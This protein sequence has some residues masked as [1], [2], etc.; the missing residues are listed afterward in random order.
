MLA[1]NMIAL[2]IGTPELEW[3]EE[4]K[5]V[6][7]AFIISKPLRWL[8]RL[9]DLLLGPSCMRSQFLHSGA[10]SM[11]KCF[12]LC[13]GMIAVNITLTS[14]QIK[15]QGSPIRTCRTEMHDILQ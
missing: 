14:H 1:R 12:G 7:V 10:A 4:E 9:R 8:W 13:L 15:F 2:H 5:F 3:F 6:F 11:R